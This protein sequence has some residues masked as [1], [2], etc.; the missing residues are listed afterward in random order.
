MRRILI[1]FAF[2]V[3]LLAAAACTRSAGPADGTTGAGAVIP[4]PDSSPHGNEPVIGAYW[5]LYPDPGDDTYS[6]VMQEKDRIPWT[7]INRLNIAFATVKDGVLTDL[8]AGDA[9]ADA[10]QREKMQSRIRE[11]VSLGRQNNPDLEI[12]VV[13]NF[14]EKVL[15]PE[16]LE[17]SRDPEKFADSV[18]EYLKDYD[19]DGYDMDWES[20]SIDD[21]APQLTSLLA[22][23]HDRFAAE[24]NS[25]RGRPYLLTHTVWPGIESAETV[26][27][28][29]DAV[30]QLN[31]MTY[32]PGETYDLASYAASYNASGFPYDRMIGGIESESGYGE[33]GGPDTQESVAAKCA[34]VREHGMAGLFEWRIDNDMRPDNSPPTYQVTGW[35]HGCLAG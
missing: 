20:H 8:P 27:G 34:L 14:D 9:P 5:Y 24:G 2:L 3:L 17:A 13:S 22:A 21:Y 10:A 30:D 23:C 31:L 18:M 33:S 12:F 25:P 11:I 6:L 1:L 35:M 19:L 16:Y 15:D 7:K 26:A 4:G 28:L 32:G 29:K